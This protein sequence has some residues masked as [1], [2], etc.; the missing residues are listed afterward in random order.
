MHYIFNPSAWLKAL[1]RKA[2]RHRVISASAAALPFPMATETPLRTKVCIIGSGP[3][4]HTAAIYAARAELKPILFEGWMA[5]D[6]APGGQLT[7]T[8]DVENFPGFPDGIMG[9]ELMD[10]CRKQSLRFGTTIFTE[11]V[12]K[13]DFSSSPFKIFSG[14]KTV[15]ADSVIVATGAVAKRLTFQGSGDGKGGFWNRGISAC[16]VCD[17]AA[18]IFRNKPLAVIGG[19]DSAMEESTFL[20]KYGSKV[21]VI[22]RRDS[23]RASKIMQSRVV[24]NPKIEVIW[25]SVVVEAYGDRVLGG[26][27]VKN[28]LTG[29]VSDLKVSG[30][31]FAI[32]HEP[33]TKFLD[34]QLQLDSDGYVLTQPGTT[35]TSVPGVF[36]AGDVQD[37]KYRQAITA[38]GTGCMA[39]LEAEHYLQ[40]IASS[41]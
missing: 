13:V 5:N 20:T 40:E 10:Q 35:K 37:K 34:G 16:A 3:A 28:M 19:G 33:A 25:N 17:G 15:L 9:S 41:D 23:F 31:F 4:A 12:N 32:G 22:H 36:A 6:I 24:S 11:T 29:E 8:T 1:L 27:K 26:L 39:A 38:A 21:Y 14:S 7:T 2:L 30:L 18:P